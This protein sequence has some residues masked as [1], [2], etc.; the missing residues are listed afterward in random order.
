MSASEQEEEEAA[1]VGEQED[2]DEV[3]S[4]GSDAE[5]EVGHLLLL[6]M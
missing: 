1:A 2:E 4:F 3:I 6:L 5:N